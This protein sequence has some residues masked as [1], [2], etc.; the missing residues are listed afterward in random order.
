MWEQMPVTPAEI[1]GI[2]ARLLHIHTHTHTHTHTGGGEGEKNEGEREYECAPGHQEY[3]TF[4]L[5]ECVSK[6]CV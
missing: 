6:P 2:Q 4:V 3:V 5:E 1:K